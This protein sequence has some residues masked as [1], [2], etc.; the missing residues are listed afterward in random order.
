M[1]LVLNVDAC[2]CKC[3]AAR[4]RSLA[5]YMIIVAAIALQPL[6]DLESRQSAAAN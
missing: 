5:V 4:E 6:T 2:C 1:P 3:A